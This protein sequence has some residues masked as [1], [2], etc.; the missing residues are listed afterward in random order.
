[1]SSCPGKAS[2]ALCPTTIFPIGAGSPSVAA[3]TVQHK[4]QQ[5]HRICGKWKLSTKEGKQS[6]KS[7]QGKHI[8]W[9]LAE[10]V[11]AEEN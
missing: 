6:G 2:P 11:G 8:W 4:Q 7:K 1:M 5:P 10:K 3:V 9:S